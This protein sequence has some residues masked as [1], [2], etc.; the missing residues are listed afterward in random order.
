MLYRET[1]GAGI[2]YI[3]LGKKL[4]A[5][6]GVIPEN[7]GKQHFRPFGS[8]IEGEINDVGYTG[9][10]FDTDLGLSYMQAR[11][12]DPVIGRFYSNDP[13]GMTD[14]HTFNRYAYANNN[15]YK[16][17]DPDGKAVVAGAAIG[18][19]VTGPACPAGAAV[20]ATIG[21][22]VDLVTIAVGVAI[23]AYNVLKD[24]VSDSSGLEGTKDEVDDFVDDLDSVSEPQS[25]DSSIRILNPG[26]KV[27]DLKGK[28]PGTTGNNGRNKTAEGGNIGTHDSSTT[29][30][31]D[32]SRAKTLDVHRPK[33]SGN[34]KYRENN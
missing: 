1:D 3:Y 29:R 2:N 33:G 24:D 14:I 22:V 6:D 4:I 34:R 8:S 20:G 9:H 25:D 18:C 15:P 21:A 16:Y 30:N 11:Y 5:K 31:S 12:Y 10:K 13:I 17:T 27:D 26:V 23:I 28:A 32:G 7:A 19:A